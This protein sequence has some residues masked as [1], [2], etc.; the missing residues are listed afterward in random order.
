[1][2][3]KRRVG[4]PRVRRVLTDAGYSLRA[5]K[6]LGLSCEVCQSLESLVIH[7]CDQNVRHNT[8]DNLQTLCKLCHDSHHRLARKEKRAVAGRMA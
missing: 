7:H 6:H 3:R 2:A 8:P 1:M 5:R 4:R